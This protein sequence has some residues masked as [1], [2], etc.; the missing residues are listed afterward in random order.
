[1]L[2]RSRKL[3]DMP[4]MNP[5]AMYAIASQMTA[6]IMFPMYMETLAFGFSLLYPLF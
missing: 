3:S 5:H 2:S 1:M 6:A 4:S